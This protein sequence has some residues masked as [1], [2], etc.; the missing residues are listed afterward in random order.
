MS[1]SHG[2][3]GAAQSQ[4]RTPPPGVCA[5]VRLAISTTLLALFS[6]CAT[7]PKPEM[8]DLKITN[9]RVLDGTGAPWFRADVGIRGNQIVAVGDLRAAAARD[10][11][12]ARNRLVAPGFIDLLGQSESS[13]LVAPQVEAKVRQGITTEVTGENRGPGPQAAPPSDERPWTTLAEYIQHL[14]KKGTAINFAF[15]VGAANARGIVIGDVNRPPT[16]DEMRQ[17]ETIIEQAMRDGA[18]G[19]STSLIYLPSMYAKTEELVNLARVAARYEGVYFSHIRDEGDRIEMALDEAFR[20]GREAGIPVN[21]WHL[22]TSGRANWGRMP[23]VVARIEAARAEG[24]DVA[25][26]MY[27]YPASST[28]LSTLAPDWAMEGGYDDLQRRL[29]IPEERAKIAE[30]LRRNLERRGAKGVYVARIGNPEQKQYEKKYIEDIAVE[31]GVAPEEAVM[32]LFE[33]NNSSPATI[34]FSMHEDDVRTALKQ[35]WVAFGADSGSP[36]PQARAA[37]T[38]VHPRAYGTMPRVIGH[39]AR[40]E[41]L[42]TIE[43]AV[44]RMTSLAASRVKFFDRGVIRAGMKADI[45]IFD[46]ATIIDKATFDDPHQF[47]EGVSDVIVN[48]V[49]ILR[50]G[51]MTG[52]LPGRVIRGKGATK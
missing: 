2:R 19:L 42:I 14:E 27:P 4:R 50:D 33:K 18:I 38:A 17:M 11:L 31:M 51:T 35:P 37:G 43:E 39:Y 29:A 49:P 48:G 46:P 28:S 44:R 8:L 15:F 26:N 45:T 22:K 1:E 32:R 12:D 20:I 23:Q 6:A 25:A 7:A 30:V 9:G 24:L 13:V 52:A 16:G 40:D 3:T 47:A 10:T 34:F 41:K 36:T 5:T 21:I